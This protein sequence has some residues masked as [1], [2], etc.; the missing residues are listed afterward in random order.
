MNTGWP[1]PGLGLASISHTSF[2]V[3]FSRYTLI[4]VKTFIIEI[5]ST[6]GA[7]QAAR[8]AALE[9]EIVELK[10]RCEDGDRAKERVSEL[11]KQVEEVGQIYVADLCLV[12]KHFY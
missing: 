10:S 6:Q 9:G 3:S 11:E 8:I 5:F 2:I 7:R 12:S 1:G 4:C